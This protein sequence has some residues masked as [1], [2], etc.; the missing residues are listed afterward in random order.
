ME[1]LLRVQTGR[2]DVEHLLTQTLE[3]AGL[4][5]YRSF[6]LREALR[7]L[8]KCDCALH[9]TPDCS[10][11]YTVL[12]TYGEQQPPTLIVAH[13]RK[14]LAQLRVSGAGSALL[15]ERLLGAL[16]GTLVQPG[17]DAA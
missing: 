3:A 9:G 2:Q 14:G 13:G 11:N 10:C 8:P 12:L 17:E 5:V 15:R 4:T 7:E 16:A 1:Y 6:S